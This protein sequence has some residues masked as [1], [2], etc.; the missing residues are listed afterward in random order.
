M[1]KF[2]Q[3]KL[4]I[5]ILFCL[6][7][8]VTFTSYNYSSNPPT[9]MT[10]APGEQN[11]TSC[12][13]GSPIS[14]GTEWDG[15]TLTGLPVGGYAPSTTYSLTLSGGAAATSKNGFSL[16]VLN[17]T[18]TMAGTL[19]SGT[20]SAVQIGSGRNYL[21]H[22]AT[23]Q[24]SYSFSWTS[25]STPSGTLTFYVSWNG[26]DG[27]NGTS[28]D[29]IYTKT[30][31]VNSGGNPP[32][33][34]ITP[35][36]TT[37]CLGDTLFLQGS[38]TNNPTGWSW[39]FPGNVP[40]SSSLQNPKLVYTTTGTK[41]VR[42][43][44]SNTFGN[45]ATVSVNINVVAKPTATITT[46][47]TSICG[48][49]S[50]LLTANSGANLS[51]QWFPTGTGNSASVFVK[52]SGSYSVRVTNAS[53]CSVTS[54][55]TKI[56][57]RNRPLAQLQVSSAQVC[58][59][60][61]IQLIA[62]Q[63]G[64]GLSYQFYLDTSLLNSSSTAQIQLAGVKSGNYKHRTYDGFCFSVFDSQA[65]FAESLLPAPI[66]NCAEAEATQIRFNW[67]SVPGAQAYSLSTD[68][69]QTW[70]QTQDTSY[71][72]Q[73]GSGIQSR[74]IQ[75]KA[76]G[77]GLCEF[78][79][80]AVFSCS[81]AGCPKRIASIPHP[82]S[83]CLGADSSFVLSI[84]P[85]SSG[86][87]SIRLLINQA[88]I[89]FKPGDSVKL[90][91]SKGLN[92]FQLSLFD[93][94]LTGCSIDT[95]ISVLAHAPFNQNLSFNYSGLSTGLCS[96]QNELLLSTNRLAQADSAW[97]TIY[98]NGNE[99]RVYP[100]GLDSSLNF[101]LAASTTWPFEV[102]ASWKNLATGCELHSPKGSFNRLPVKK[103][104]FVAYY[105]TKKRNPLGLEDTTSFPIKSRLW[106]FGDGESDTLRRVFHLYPEDKYYDC[107]LILE[108]TN[109]CLDTALQSVF[110][111]PGGLQDL[112][113]IGKAELF[114]NP[115]TDNLNLRITTLKKGQLE[116]RIYD[117]EARLHSRFS[118][119][120]NAG[121][122]EFR[123]PLENLSPG[124][125]FLEADL[126][127]VVSRIRFLKN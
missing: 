26:S 59:S 109:G 103:A 32:V 58:E 92:N 73:V 48:N 69:G 67:L 40:S 102:S 115:A 118:D 74:I 42:L 36:S 96:Y 97:F 65:V 6:M 20:G 121:E 105:L 90:F 18:N 4:K 76:Q 70:F 41:Q 88:Q 57:K 3:S 72:L 81:N 99:S 110:G 87:A 8:F 91:L 55:P 94:T 112:A 62:L 104:G 114:P 106:L 98:A 85:F 53:N 68:S 14:S 61:T 116:F 127:G 9:G 95:S 49:D 86:S 123:F 28:G 113:G 19:I 117:A 43:T 27:S 10:N 31:T 84:P 82:D 80:L 2:Y 78:G 124:I 11:C 122:N 35:S 46:A 21:N 120:L 37:I 38:A 93:S 71:V 100:T 34:T 25:P 30:F 7:S 107:R 15:I 108:D 52:D 24:S 101:N 1:K 44:A 50:V 12:H 119:R 16:T 47:T 45:S 23:A 13:S 83:L 29:D 39:L 66:L 111:N 22:T 64:T 63:T 5:I 126:D 89:W 125:Y 60:D 79:K 54:A 56:S 17:S 51:Y 33:A 75:V 77:S